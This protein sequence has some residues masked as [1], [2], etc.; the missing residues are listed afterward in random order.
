MSHQL[1]AGGVPV[2]SGLDPA[3]PL[4]EHSHQKAEANNE[5]AVISYAHPD[6]QW[7]QV[8]AAQHFAL[9]TLHWMLSTSPK[10]FPELNNLRH[11]EHT[12]HKLDCVKLPISKFK[13]RPNFITICAR[14]VEMRYQLILP[15]RINPAKPALDEKL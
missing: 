13:C 2:P 5:H 4:P 15:I 12:V 3:A 14:V 10:S 11:F 6:D 9:V 7:G 1:K 8:T